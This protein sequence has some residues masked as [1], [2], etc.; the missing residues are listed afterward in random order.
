V[1]WRNTS[2]TVVWTWSDGGA[3]LAAPCISSL[4]DGEGAGLTTSITVRDNA[5]NE[6]TVESPAVSIDKTA[7][8]SE[9]ALP[10]M[11]AQRRAGVLALGTVRSVCWRGRAGTSPR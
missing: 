6:I 9:G 11:A 8:A 7:P 10:V 5:G 3:G 4:I 1:G 2:V